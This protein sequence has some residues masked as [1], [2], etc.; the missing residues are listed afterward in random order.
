MKK[1]F[2]AMLALS[3]LLASP[4]LRAQN[5]NVLAPNEISASYGVSLIGISVNTLV[6]IAGIAGIFSDELEADIA[7]IKSGGSKG[8]INASYLYHPNSVYAIGGSVG[9][10]RLSVNMQDKTGSI[11]A[12]SANIIFAMVDAKVNWFRQDIFGMYTKFGLGVMC[13]NSN[14]MEEHD[15]NLW[16]PTAQLSLIG[17]ELGRQFCGFMEL[18]AGMQGILQVGLKYHF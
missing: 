17:M 3:C 12:A 4:S 18:G 5:I 8:V 2:V 9:F 11:T 13:I 16:L 10:N 15:G 1:I 14:V 6:N 7:S